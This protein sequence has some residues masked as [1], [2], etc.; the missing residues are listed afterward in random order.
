MSPE[1]LSHSPKSDPGPNVHSGSAN[2]HCSDERFAYKNRRREQRKKPASFPKTGGPSILVYVKDDPRKA[3]NRNMYQQ[4]GMMPQLPVLHQTHHV[5]Q[6]Y[7]PLRLPYLNPSLMMMPPLPPLPPHLLPNTFPHQRQRY[8]S[9]PTLRNY[10]SPQ[11]NYSTQRKKS[12]APDFPQNLNSQPPIS[13]VPVSLY[14]HVTIPSHDAATGAKTAATGTQLNPASTTAPQFYFP[15]YYPLSGA[16]PVQNTLYQNPFTPQN[17]PKTE[18]NDHSTGQSSMYAN[19]NVAAANSPIDSRTYYG[20]RYSSAQSQK[21]MKTEQ[22]DSTTQ[23]GAPLADQYYEVDHSYVPVVSRP[24]V[25]PSVYTNKCDCE[26]CQISPTDSGVSS[27]IN[28]SGYGD[29][30]PRTFSELKDDLKDQEDQINSLSLGNGERPLLSCDQNN[31]TFSL[32]PDSLA[33]VMGM[34]HRENR[35]QNEQLF[36]AEK[37]QIRKKIPCRNLSQSGYCHFGETCWFNH[38][39][40][41]N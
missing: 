14:P 30:A 3:S 37:R 12:S 16:V 10:S 32:D 19:Q 8:N 34:A 31:P 15:S 23:S 28:D 6:G 40:F 17:F 2:P 22:V 21:P 25:Y 33:R 7:D 27:S 5:T 1:S 41:N 20:S 11:I 4:Y 38:N 29:A 39:I 26:K 24:S 18:P 36:L 13:S 35:E 9:G